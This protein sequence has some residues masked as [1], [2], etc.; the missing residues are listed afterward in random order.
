MLMNEIRFRAVSTNIFK[1]RKIRRMTD[2]ELG[3]V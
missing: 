3:E 1:T 2:E